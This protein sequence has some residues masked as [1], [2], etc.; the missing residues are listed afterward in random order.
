MRICL[1]T[2]TLCMA[3]QESRNVKCVTGKTELSHKLLLAKEASGKTFNQIAKECGLTN[4]YTAQLFLAQVP[5]RAGEACDQ[6]CAVRQPQTAPHRA[7]AHL[8]EDT[9]PKLKAAVPAISDEMLAAMK[10]SPM[11]TYDPQIVQ[12]PLVYRLTEVRCARC[13]CCMRHEACNH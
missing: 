10:K 4:L 9:A 3:G 8:K 6:S 13:I 11:R 2:H 7:Q 5:R 12:D 1:A